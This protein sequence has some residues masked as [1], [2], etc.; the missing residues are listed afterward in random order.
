[1]I[2]SANQMQIENFI[3]TGDSSILHKL[4]SSRYTVLDEFWKEKPILFQIYQHRLA[5]TQGFQVGDELHQE[6]LYKR[7]FTIVQLCFIPQGDGVE[8]FQLEESMDFPP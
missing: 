8:G 7:S 2:V 6:G 5:Q 1:M 4:G 3:R